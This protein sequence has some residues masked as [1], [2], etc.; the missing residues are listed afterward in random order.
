MTVEKHF[1]LHVNKGQ[2]TQPPTLSFSTLLSAVLN[3]CNPLQCILSLLL[4]HHI[5]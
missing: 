3:S 4:Q 5:K 1:R 2:R